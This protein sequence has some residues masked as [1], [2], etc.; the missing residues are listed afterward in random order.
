MK[1][2]FDVAI[3]GG[4]INGCGCAA[5]AALRGL[6]VALIEQGDLASQTSSKSTKLIH[7]GL[8]Y[9]EQLELGLVKKAL[10]ERENLLKLAPHLVHPQSFVLPHQKKS[11]PLWLLRVALFIYDHL[12]PTNSLPRS[13]L[14]RAKG[15]T[16]Y[17]KPLMKEM[18]KGCLFYDCATC[19]VRLTIANAIQAHEHGASIMTHTTLV[20]SAVIDNL[21]QLT[22]QPTTKPA[23]QI[24]ARA[25]INCTGPW[26]GEMSQLLSVPL[27]HEVSLVKGSHLLVHP[28]YTGDH[29]YLLQH[30]DQR[31]IFAIPYHGY[32]LVGTTEIAYSG[33][34]KD[35]H[36]EPEE[37]AYLCSVIN[38]YFNK[39]VNESQIIA[40][41]SG[42]RTLVSDPHKSAHALSR[43]YIYHFTQ[44]PGPA[45]TVYGG[46][47]TTYRQ[48]ATEAIDRLHPIFPDLPD[49]IT[50]LTPLPGAI[51]N[52]MDFT[53][54][55][56]FAREKYHW[57]D[58]ETLNHYLNHY[59]TRTEQLLAHKENIE[60]LGI[61][62][63]EG[64]YQAEVDYLLTNE[65]AI[66][67]EDILWRRTK[68]GL[69]TRE[70]GQRALSNYLLNKDRA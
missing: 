36:I 44:T 43:D 65:W 55:K 38:H 67:C 21:W 69:T 61:S 32:T 6:K 28:L 45:V 63:A 49:S 62:F 54:Y 15:N 4:G 58:S 20:E 13:K 57:L 14:I 25:V 33:S 60:S 2:I 56:T 23:F 17:F 5:D 52:G 66:H 22:L 68:L 64:F 37:V 47:L 70:E 12:S 51:L 39:Q 31:V 26:V 9:L 10:N 48:L 40:T 1:T 53:T 24:Q 18:T 16:D 41:W 30:D 3:I 19:D 8:R 42:L 46:K 11:R 34:P 35:V 29:A 27:V 7:G 50:H 59:G